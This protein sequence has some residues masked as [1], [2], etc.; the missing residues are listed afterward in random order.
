MKKTL[1]LLIIILGIIST[2]HTQVTSVDYQIKYNDS[3]CQYDAYI[4]INAGS[5]MTVPQRIQFNAQFSIAVPTGTALTVT[6]SYMP[7]QSNAAYTGTVPLTWA[8]KWSII[9]PAAQSW[10]DFYSI[11]P[12]LGIT[13]H[14][15]NLNA[16]D[17]VKLF[18]IAV[19]TIFDCSQGIRI[20]ENGIDPDSQAPG[21]GFADY[22][23]GFTLGSI[24]QIYSDNSSQKYPPQPEIVSITNGCNNGIEIDLTAETSTCQMPMTYAWTGAN[25]YFA[26]TEDISLSSDTANNGLYKVI[27]TDAFGCK[28]SISIDATSKPNAGADITAC[29]GSTT[30]IYGTEPTTGTWA[31][32]STN[33][34]GASLSPLAGGATEVT[35]S[36]F[37]SGTF[38]MVYS[39]PGCSDTMQITLDCTELPVACDQIEADDIICDFDALGLVEGT[40]QESNSEGNQPIG[41]LC[42]D[43]DGVQNI[44]WLGFV[45]LEGDYEIVVNTTNCFSYTGGINGV[46]VGIYSDCD[47]SEQSKVF[48]EN[49]NQSENQIRIASNLLTVGQT[50]FLYIDGFENSICYYYIDV[51]GFYDNTYCTDLSKVTGVAYIDDN[52]NGTYEIGEELL[53]NAL[54]SLSPGDFSVLTNE[55]GK[56]IINTPKGGTTLTAKMNEGDWINNELTIEDLSVFETCVEGIDFGFVPNSPIQEAKISVANTITRCDWET[57]FYFTVENTGTIDLN[58]NFEFT[59]DSKTSYFATNLIGLQV[60]GE[61]ASGDLG[62]MKPFEVREFWITLKMPSGS[63]VQPILDFKTTLYNEGGLEMD[64]YEQSEQLKCSYDPNDKRE[65]PNREGEENLTLMDEE[66][67]YTIRFQNNGNDTAF[68]VKIIDQL[69]PNIEPTSIRVINSSHSVE[70]CIENENLIFLFEDI[71]LVDSMTNYDGSQGFV[72]FRCDTKEGRAENTIVKNAADIIFDTNLPIVTNTTINTLVSELCTNVTTE[73]GIKICEGEN[74]NGYEETGIYTE[75]FPLTYGCDS[76]V[77]I[78]LEVQGITYS[79]QEIEICEGV[80]FEVNGNEYILDESQEIVDTVENALGCITNILIFDVTVNPVQLVEIDT[81]IC[82]GLDYNGLTESGFYTIFSIDAITGCGIITNIELEVLP[83]SDPNCLVGIDEEIETAIS[84]YPN[85]AL[86]VFFV[87]AETE[88]EALSIYTMTYQKVVDLKFDHNLNKI[89]IS[90]DNL[91][92]GI[93]I[94]AVKSAG[95]IVYKKVIVK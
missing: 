42:D 5:A 41:A 28:D 94:I 23:N 81:I 77:V 16:G 62:T 40:L 64:A 36:G 92:T 54:I 55:E 48:C 69:D 85:P 82:E 52:E 86:D 57:K 71:N 26:T 76:I 17:T 34:F 93:Y 6:E 83:M 78:N 43:G 32:S 1:L 67:E 84:V 27:I 8:A 12:E 51:E 72:S 90:T 68:Q 47:F 9:S 60:N 15:N 79:S 13:S 73:V 74:Y 66:L 39:I 25:L 38:D 2:T 50:Y 7:L 80:A 22:S 20:F 70:T 10:S 59:F 89:E 33:S 31:Q 45:G 63:S 37:A 46:Q 61:V 4:I 35:F 21:M 65:F 30:I 95:M 88:I 19:D 75:F 91:N 44:Y 14:Y 58:A 56:Y 11:T 49:G 87:E 3:E 53:R 24:S 29:S 18:S